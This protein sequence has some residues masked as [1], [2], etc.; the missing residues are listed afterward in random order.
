MAAGGVRLLF[1]AFA[2]SR[3][4]T[5]F[6]PVSSRYRSRYRRMM[7][8]FVGRAHRPPGA[9]RFGGFVGWEQCPFATFCDF[10]GQPPVIE[11]KGAHAKTREE[12]A[13][14]L[15]LPRGRSRLLGGFEAW[16]LFL[17]CALLRKDRGNKAAKPQSR[18]ASKG[19]VGRH[20]SPRPGLDPIWE[21]NPR[22]TPWAIVCRCSAPVAAARAQ[23]DT[24][25]WQ[26]AES[27]FSSRPSRLRVI[28]PGSSP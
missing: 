10:C 4:R 25:G 12:W 28:E 2:A 19:E 27:G 1:A 24:A 18:K 11:A 22:L 9:Y 23:V 13:V 15:S 8:G 3:D 7:R 17:R 26:R 21:R 6:F 20:L 16:R 5:R 14:L